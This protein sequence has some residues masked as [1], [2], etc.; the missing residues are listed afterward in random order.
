MP[1]LVRSLLCKRV[2]TDSGTNDVTFVDC[3]EQLAPKQLPAGLPRL[4]LATLWKPD[5]D[6]QV[7]PALRITVVGPTGS[8]VFSQEFPPIEIRPEHSSH[9]INIDLQGAPVKAY[10]DHAIRVEVRAEGATRWKKLA[11]IPLEIVEPPR[12]SDD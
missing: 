9:R 4:F 5:K 6:E 7:P 2:I 12:E 8:K 3:V 1:R 10:G 11:D